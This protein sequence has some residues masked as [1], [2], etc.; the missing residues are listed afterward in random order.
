MWVEATAPGRI[1]FLGGVADYS[2]SWVLQA[3]IHWETKV[4]ISLADQW[5]FRSEQAED[6]ILSDELWLE[7]SAIAHL[8][9]VRQALEY[10][11]VPTW[12]KYILGCV[13]VLL[14][15]RKLS[16]PLHQLAFTVDSA[17]PL[18]MGVSSSAAIEVATLRALTALFDLAWNKTEL[19]CTAQRA[20]N[21]IVGAPCG[22]MDQLTSAYGRTRAFLPILCRPDEL[23]EPIPLPTGVMIVGW[24]SGVKHNIGGSP[25]ARARAG[26]FMGKRILETEL[27]KKIAY[28]TEIRV[29]ELTRVADKLP[30][31]M[32]GREFVQRY[33]PHDDP[34]TAFPKLSDEPETRDLGVPGIGGA[35]ELDQEYPVRAAAQFPVEECHRVQLA[36]SLLRSLFAQPD[37]VRIDQLH[38]IGELMF[39]SHE[40]YSAMG[41]GSAETD[42]M[43]DALKQLGPGQGVYGARISA[44]G[45]GGTVVVLLQ[46]TALPHVDRLRRIFNTPHPLIL[47]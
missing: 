42:E 2:G 39:Q 33:G 25:Y 17:V 40:G 21:E 47:V 9:G 1:D 34:L 12:V 37:R 14:H 24:P 15:E 20:E 31:R 18:G 45:S 19:A 7:L 3:P 38:L 46:D 22:L 26:A 23:E 32:L 10:A 27:K 36:K 43:V 41:L 6:Y 35:S 5:V 8:A 4:A 13:L 44:G 29:S 11:R 16:L 28:L 30:L